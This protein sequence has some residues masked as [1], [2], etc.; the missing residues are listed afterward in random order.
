MRL[1]FSRIEGGGHAKGLP[2]D[3]GRRGIVEN[4]GAVCNGGNNPIEGLHKVKR[5]GSSE[6]E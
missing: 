2:G 1:C 6:R 4:R 3:A 5:N